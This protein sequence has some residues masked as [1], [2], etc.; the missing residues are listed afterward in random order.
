MKHLSAFVSGALFSVGLAVSGMINPSK[1]EGFLDFTGN[2]DPT[3][4]FVMGGALVVFAPAYRWVVKTERPVFEA[5]F[6]VP[7]R[8]DVSWQLVT[9]SAVFGAG[10]GITGFC[11]AAAFSALPALSYNAIGVVIGMAVGIV[12]MR[13]LRKILAP[14]LAPA[15]ADF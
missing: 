9:G 6:D 10:W 8:R 11:P 14:E 4:A 15:V 12:G 2:W 3:L 7:A 5:K 1:I 13:T